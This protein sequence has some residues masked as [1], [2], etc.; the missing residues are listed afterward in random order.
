MEVESSFGVRKGAWTA[1]EDILLRQCVE[2]YG[3]VKWHQ[4]PLK[5][6]TASQRER[7]REFNFFFFCIWFK[8]VLS[9]NSLF[10]Q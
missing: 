9:L 8:Q 3:Q 1:E 4:V 10:S 6:G 2:K 7:E 5:A